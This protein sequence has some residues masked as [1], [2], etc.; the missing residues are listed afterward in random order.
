MAKFKVFVKIT[1]EQIFEIE[2]DS[3]EEAENIYWNCDDEEDLKK[4]HE[5]EIDRDTI[6]YEVE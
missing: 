2:A 5:K 4:S 1:K 3:K 6:V